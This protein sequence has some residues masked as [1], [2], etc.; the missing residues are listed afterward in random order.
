M[1]LVKSKEKFKELKTVIRIKSDFSVFIT[2]AAFPSTC[3]FC[4]LTYSTLYLLFLSGKYC[5]FDPLKSTL[6]F[7]ENQP[8]TLFKIS[9]R[10]SFYLILCL[11][12]ESTDE[13]N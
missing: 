11:D 4:A 7:G 9:Y 2:F 3:C 12:K 10:Q 6:I 5:S 8:V 1:Y 13:A